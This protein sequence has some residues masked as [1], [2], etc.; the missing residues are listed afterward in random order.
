MN[1]YVEGNF[2]SRH[3]LLAKILIICIVD[4]DVWYWYVEENGL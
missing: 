4:I 1:M 2:V 3:I